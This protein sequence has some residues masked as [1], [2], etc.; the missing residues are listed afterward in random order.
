MTPLQTKI[1]HIAKKQANLTDEQ[2]RQIL[3]DTAGVSSSRLLT[4]DG[5]ENV[6]AVLEGLGF[7][8]RDKPGDYWRRRSNAKGEGIDSRVAWKI[9]EL[10]KESIYELATLVYRHSHHRTREVEQLYPKEA[11]EIIE[12]LKKSN[13][14]EGGV[15]INRHGCEGPL[16]PGAAKAIAEA[17]EKLKEHFTQRHVPV[18]DEEVPF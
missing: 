5:F 15:H 16:T 2:Y 8:E 6:M 13:E 17:A 18:T 4:N 3:A 12:M 14:R 7:R 1:I 10:A 11:W 9:R